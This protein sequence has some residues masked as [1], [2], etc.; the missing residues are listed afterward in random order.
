MCPYIHSEKHSPTRFTFSVGL[1]EYGAVFIDV[2]T[3]RIFDGKVNVCIDKR[4]PKTVKF[5]LI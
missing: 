2:G 5:K 4:G 3:R 1:N